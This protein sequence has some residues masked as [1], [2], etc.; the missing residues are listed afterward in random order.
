MEQKGESD[1][2]SSQQRL[3]TIKVTL[4]IRVCKEG[5]MLKNWCRWIVVLEK[6][7]ENPLDSKE[8]KSANLKGDPPWIFIGRTDAEAEAP[9]FWWVMQT[10]DTLVKALMLGKDWGQKKGASENEMAGWHHWCNEYELGQTLGDG[11]G[12]GGLA[13]CSPWGRKEWDIGTKQQQQLVPVFPGGS[14]AKNPPSK[15]GDSGSIPESGRSPGEGNSNPLQYSWLENPKDRGTW[16]A[17]V[18]GVAK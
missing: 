17:T 12:Q 8:I 16:W 1:K 9:V 10:D 2:A 3:G 15:A 14:V 6:T 18:H 11:K 13:C 4:T 7:L 5:R